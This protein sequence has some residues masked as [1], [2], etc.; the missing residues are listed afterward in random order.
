MITQKTQLLQYVE[1]KNQHTLGKNSKEKMK[2]AHGVKGREETLQH[3][4]D[5]SKYGT[6][7]NKYRILQQPYQE[8]RE[9][10]ITNLVLLENC[11]VASGRC[12]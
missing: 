8:N 1:S 10:A 7:G 4:L 5:C 12:N 2:N 11:T 6:I 3:L 9:D